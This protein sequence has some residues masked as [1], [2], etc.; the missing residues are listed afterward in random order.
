MSIYQRVVCLKCLLMYNIVNNNLYPKY[1]KCYM[2]LKPAV[3]YNLRQDDTLMCLFHTEKYLKIHFNLMV[4][5]YG[6]TYQQNSKKPL[7]MT[8]LSKSV[9]FM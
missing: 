6:T 4:C 5:Y 3:H 8:I 7:H 1:L 2:K 9:K